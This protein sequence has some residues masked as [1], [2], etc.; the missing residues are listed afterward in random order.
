M[1]DVESTSTSKSTDPAPTGTAIMEPHLMKF[2]F[3]AWY[4]FLRIKPGIR[5]VSLRCQHDV[6]DKCSIDC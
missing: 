1:K 6:T 3:P 2:R 4:R 5:L